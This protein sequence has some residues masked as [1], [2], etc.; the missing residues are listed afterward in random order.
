MK[1]FIVR[2]I[3]WKSLVSMLKCVWKVLH[4][5]WTFN[6]KSYI[7]KLYTRLLLQMPL[8]VPAW[9]TLCETNNILFSKNYWKLD[10]VNVKSWKNI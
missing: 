1:N 3:F 2:T 8:H 9:T 6:G 10:K 5:N 7:K 4:K